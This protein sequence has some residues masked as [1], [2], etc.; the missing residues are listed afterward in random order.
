[1]EIETIHKRIFCNI[2]YLR[3][4]HNLSQK[5]MAQILGVC[6]GS[7][8]RIEKGDYSIKLN[9]RHICRLCDY[10]SIS[11]DAL[12]YVEF[13]KKIPPLNISGGVR[14]FTGGSRL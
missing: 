2:C 7:V 9:A 13:D 1:M 12:F 6:V 14:L 11:V 3:K 8:C 10:F 5:Q 4:Q